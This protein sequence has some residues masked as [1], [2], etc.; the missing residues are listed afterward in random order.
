MLNIPEKFRIDTDSKTIDL[1]PLVI[2]DERFY[3]ST[4]KE[5][6][7]E[8]I[9]KPLIK[10][11]GSIKESIDIQN[12]TFKISSITLSLYNYKYDNEYLSDMIFSPSVMNKKI[13]IYMKSQSAKNLGDCLEVYSG[14]VKNIKE[15]SGVLSLSAEDKTDEVLNKKVPYKFVRDD[16]NLPEKYRNEP[17]PI[18]YGYVD[19]APCVYYDLYSTTIEN[20]SRDWAI[21]PDLFAIKSIN[22]PYI[23]SNDTYGKIP[24]ESWIFED[25]KGGTIY[26]N[27][28][29]DQYQILGNRILI[30]KAIEMGESPE[31]SIQGVVAPV[32]A[33]GM[34]EVHALQDASFNSS[35][36]RF[37]FRENQQQTISAKTN[38]VAYSEEEG[39]NPTENVENSYLMVKDFSSESG[40]DFP[41]NHWLWGDQSHPDYELLFGESTMNFE[42]NNFFSDSKVVKELTINNES[43]KEINHIV[44]LNF[45]LEANLTELTDGESPKF[46]FGYTDTS[47]LVWNPS[48]Y[49]EV[50]TH[51]DTTYTVRT[52]EIYIEDSDLPGGGVS[53]YA[54]TKNPSH[55]NFFIGQRHLVGENWT[56]ESQTGIVNWLKIIKLKLFR[57]VLLKDFIDFEIFADVEG[58]VDTVSGDY[59]GERQLTSGERADFSQ[60]REGVQTFS[61]R[62]SI[63]L[64]RRITDTKVTPR[65]TKRVLRKKGTKY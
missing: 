18:V 64:D 32:T 45:I 40:I 23:F 9:F 50:S 34:I 29:S 31:Q 51:P 47:G 56:F 60:R 54:Q 1:K 8:F 37:D 7:E 20:G 46:I 41:F 61:P 15:S 26:R 6:L 30:P 43:S 49:N 25:Q 4:S 13:T 65:I 39:I 57:R 5:S 63:S 22:F 12:K 62:K 58:R 38:I 21:T 3:L 52:E 53:T 27:G 19:K 11:I 14:Y 2:I 55:N 35:F 28:T 24:T 10:N 17:I 16:I 59:T 42:V 33:F 44:Q 48:S 36:F